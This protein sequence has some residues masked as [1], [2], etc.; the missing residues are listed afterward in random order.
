M[1]FSPGSLFANGKYRIERLL[2]AGAFGEVYA[3]T[4][5][6]LDRVEA[7]KVLIASTGA[8][9]ASRTTHAR[10]RFSRE[11]AIAARAKHAHVIKVYDHDSV[12]GTFYMTME[13]A[14]CGSVLELVSRERPIPIADV[15]RIVR[16]AAQGLAAL[17]AIG[18]IH[19]DVKPS[20]LLLT[21]DRHVLVADFGLAQI[22]GGISQR[23]ALASSAHA[24]PGTPDY[25]SPEHADPRSMTPTSDVYSLGCVAF[26]LLT[27]QPWI[28]AQ[29]RVDRP[30]F[31]RSEVPPWLDEIALRMLMEQPGLR[32]SDAADRQKRYVHMNQVLADLD[33]GGGAATPNLPMAPPIEPPPMPPQ[34]EPNVRSESRPASAEQDVPARPNPST[35]PAARAQRS[36]LQPLLLL[37]GGVMAAALVVGLLASRLFAGTG[38]AA[39]IATATMHAPP[40]TATVAPG[41]VEPAA[42][43][44]TPAMT[45]TPSE[46]PLPSRTPTPS[47]TPAPSETP[48]PEAT[49]TPTETSTPQCGIATAIRISEA[50]QTTLGCATGGLERWNGYSQLF[51]GGRMLLSYDQNANKKR[52]IVA[53]ADD[54][55]AWQVYYDPEYVPR[56]DDTTKPAMYYWPCARA[57]KPGETQPPER[58]GLPWR[59][60]GRVWCDYAEIQEALGRVPIGAGEEKPATA[61]SQAFENGRVLQFDG[62]VYVIVFT[63]SETA[64]TVDEG[65]TAWMRPGS[66][67]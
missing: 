37:T 34:T 46:T 49:P 51:D 54:R 63:G 33:A 12:D 20:N 3:V 27:G 52:R 25:M 21:R 36:K 57:I 61:R 22:S 55:R 17:H 47:H 53:I 2:G 9:D 19:R 56:M 15:V 31:L 24:H 29:S 23:S 32:A 66:W 10:E 28:T 50:D 62:K 13:L 7:M 39:T 43:T 42:D 16:E 38:A 26:E 59:G 1:M 30:S 40:G 41:I 5:L 14:E 11:A 60:F 44:A 8:A 58:S 48:L 45:A 6:R 67:K 64:K 35:P 65:A 4:N 18:A